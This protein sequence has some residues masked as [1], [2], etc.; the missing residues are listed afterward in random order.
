M[1]NKG[2]T[3]IL[4]Y[5]KTKRFE[6]LIFLSVFLLIVQN[7]NTILIRFCI[8]QKI[9]KFYF[10]VFFSVT[11]IREDCIKGNKKSLQGLHPTGYGR[12]VVRRTS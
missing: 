7:S 9:Q 6:K 5:T 3:T 12:L 10:S 4:V 1:I 11:I 8:F 2:K